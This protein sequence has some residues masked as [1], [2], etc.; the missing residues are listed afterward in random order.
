MKRTILFFVLISVIS[1]AYGQIETRFFPDG[2]AFD[3]VQ[4]IKN[5]PKATIA[6]EFPTF[7][8][9]QLIEEDK[10]KEG[11]DI[12]FRFGKGFDTNITLADGKWTG[13]EGG[14]AMVYGIPV[15]R[16]LFH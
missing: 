4:L 11:V 10:Q 8:I 7:N 1:M 13:M 3:H 6:K 15:S 2:N 14:P 12:P 9:Q 5:H 16:G